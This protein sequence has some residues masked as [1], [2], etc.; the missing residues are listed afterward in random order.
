[1]NAI[2]IS[3]VTGFLGSGKTTLL[4]E[5]LSRPDFALTAAVVNEFGEIGLDGDLIVRND[6]QV[7]ETTTGCLCCTIRGDIRDDL[8]DLHDR[9]RLGAV[10]PFRRVVVETTGLAD[11]APVLHALMREWPLNCLF[12]LAG[13]TTLVDAVTGDATLDR[14][15]ESLR[16][17]AMADRLVLTK[18]DLVRDPA[19]RDDLERLRLSLRRLNPTAPLLDRNAPDFDLRLLLGGALY[20]PGGRS[21]TAR[22]WLD[23]E[24]RLATLEEERGRAGRHEVHRHDVNRHG[25]AIE[26][27]TLT[28][29]RPLPGR[30]LRAA[31]ELLVANYGERLLRVKG[32]ANL[33]ER[34]ER[35][36]VFHGVQHVFHEPLH[37]PA[38]RGDDR[39]SR[40]V[41]V[42]DGLPRAAVEMLLGAV[43]GAE[44]QLENQP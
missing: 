26:T 41:F 24:A 33:L 18:T 13:V 29:E 17:V 14:Y 9:R 38:W 7:V 39:R 20:D 3:V 21:A 35:P 1:V 30:R 32:I 4:R 43:L 19:S 28:F 5:L 37:L 44:V 27:F 23:E 2:P 11:P 31:L 42:T 25:R 36:F 22:R 12:R 34:P 6:R 8:L 15:A 10:P 16:Q 40:L